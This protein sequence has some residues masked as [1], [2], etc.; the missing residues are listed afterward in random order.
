MSDILKKIVEVKRQEV[1]AALKRKPL[2]AMR[3]DAE[4]RVLTRDFEGALRAKIAAGQAA[5][6]A[7]VKKASPSKGVIREDFYPEAIAKGYAAGG[8]SCLSVLT[9]K[10]FFQGGFLRARFW[11]IEIAGQA[12]RGGHGFFEERVER[13]GTDGLAHGLDFFGFRA[14]VAM[15]K[16][17][18]FRW[19]KYGQAWLMVGVVGS[20]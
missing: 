11:Q 20:R 6:I 15:G 17:G 7:E 10:Q 13:A 5:V 19:I 12:D 8:A 3:A 14:D 2:H 18:H 4:S 9:D 1:A 16:C